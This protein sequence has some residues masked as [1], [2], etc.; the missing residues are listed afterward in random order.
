MAGYV[1]SHTHSHIQLKKSEIFHT[2][3]RSMQG[4]QSKRK[5]IQ[6]ISTETNLFVISK[7]EVPLL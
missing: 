1:H 5:Q 4:F 7:I 6:I 3:T 2:Y